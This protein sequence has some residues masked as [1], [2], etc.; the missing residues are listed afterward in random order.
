[1]VT[2]NQLF[3][4]GRRGRKKFLWARLLMGAPQKR[5]RVLRFF[6]TTPRKPNSARRKVAK[7]I[8]SNNKTL[9]AKLVGEGSAPNKYAVVLVRGRGAKDTPRVNYSMIR[10]AL[11]CLPL[12]Q[13][14][15]KRSIFG[16]SK[17]K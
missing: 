11:E 13:K 17:N 2:L 3:R 9:L 10:G 15:R 6:T 7:I 5:G 1:M 12:F 8:L 14:N 16:V 4:K